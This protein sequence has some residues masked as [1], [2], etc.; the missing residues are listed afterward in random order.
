MDIGELSIAVISLWTLCISLALKMTVCLG[1]L[2]WRRSLSHAEHVAH[3]LI[4]IRAQLKQRIST[5][6]Y[7]QVDETFIKV[8][9]P[10]RRGRSRDAYLWAIWLRGKKRLS[11]SS[12][13]PEAVR[14]STTFS[15]WSGAERSKPMAHACIQRPSNIGPRPRCLDV[16][17]TCSVKWSLR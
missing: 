10:D 7:A 17:P 9:D 14:C 2:F 6:G 13:C 1:R 8:L 15:T 16:W 12:P 5:G 3:I 11:W 4:T